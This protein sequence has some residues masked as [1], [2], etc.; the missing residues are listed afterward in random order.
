[1]DSSAKSAPVGGE[2]LKV[3]KPPSPQADKTALEPLKPPSPKDARG[4]PSTGGAPPSPTHVVSGHN[5]VGASSGPEP[6]E[7][8]EASPP[9]PRSYGL[10][11]AGGYEIGEDSSVTQS[12][13]PLQQHSRVVES[14]L[15]NLEFIQVGFHIRWFVTTAI[16]TEAD[17][18]NIK[19]LY[20]ILKSTSAQ[21]DVSA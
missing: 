21:I 9:S 8:P 20:T 12:Q 15:D 4:S 18:E 1:M 7:S 3:D 19:A 11:F 14:L 10:G 6:A 2:S 5:P 13:K 16:D 17:R